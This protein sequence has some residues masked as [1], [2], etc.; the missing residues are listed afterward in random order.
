MPPFD[1]G[2]G[3]QGDVHRSR[4]QDSQQRR[5]HLHGA[6]CEDHDPIPAFDPEVPQKACDLVGPLVDLAIGPALFF[7]EQ[8]QSLRS[9]L[10]LSF[11]QLVDAQILRVRRVRIVP[12]VD[13]L[14]ELGGSE[15]VQFPQA[16]L[17]F[18]H[19]FREGLVKVADQALDRLLREALG[20]VMNRECEALSGD[21]HDVQGVTR[22]ALLPTPDHPEGRGARVLF[23][24]LDRHHGLKERLTRI[25]ST[26]LLD[27]QQWAVLM[28]TDPYVPP[29]QIL[30][31]LCPGHRGRH[32]DTQRQRVDEGPD[33]VLDTGQ[34]AGPA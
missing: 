23:R 17:W 28:L 32:A 33:H 8:S 18:A 30:H 4:L 15:K 9:L 21:S 29:L 10:G 7:E 12:L 3:I 22:V 5:D 6:L 13:E 25:D 14:G 34:I 11:E 24:V 27:H 16:S 31:P 19:K 20:V 26:P 1:R 2:V